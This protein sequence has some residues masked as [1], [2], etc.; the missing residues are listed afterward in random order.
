MSILRANVAGVLCRAEG[1]IPTKYAICLWFNFIF[2]RQKRRS[3]CVKNGSSAR[4]TLSSCYDPP[5]EVPVN[6]AIRPCV[7]MWE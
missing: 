3:N 5:P 1:P 7:D 2:Q 4:A 6:H